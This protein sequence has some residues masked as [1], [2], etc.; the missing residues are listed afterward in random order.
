MYIPLG[1]KT[2]Y[3]LLQSLIKIKELIEFLSDNN[4]TSCGIIDNN[5]SYVMEFIN[6]CKKH[7]IKPNVGLSVKYYNKDIYLYAINYNGLQELFKINSIRQDREL[8]K[9]DVEK[10]NLIIVIP[11]KNRELIKD[12]NNFYISYE[13]ETEK[14]ESLLFTNNVVFINEVYSIYKNDLKYLDYLKSISTN[15]TIIDM[16]KNNYDNNYILDIN[17]KSTNKFSDRINIEIPLNNKYIPKYINNSYEYLVALSKK[18]LDK[19]LAGKNNNEYLSRLKYELDVINEMGFCDYFLIVYDYVK[20][21]KSNNILVGPGRGSAAGS[22]VSYTLGITEVDPIK[23]NLLFERFLNKDRITMPDIDID[24]EYTKRDQV[25]DYVKEKYGKDFVAPIMTYGTLGTKQVIRDVF[26]IFEIDEKTTSGVIAKINGNLNLK[27]NLKN[28]NIKKIILDIKEVKDAFNVALKLEGLKKYISIHAAGVIISSKD[29]DKVI[30]IVKQNNIILTGYT[31]EYLEELGLLKMDF[32]AL[33]NL[34]IISNILNMVNNKIKLNEIPLDDEKTY[35][36][37]SSGNTDGVFQFDTSGMKNFIVKLKPRTFSDLIAAVALFRPGPMN[38]IDSFI[39]RKNKEEKITYLDKSLEN[40][41]CDTYGI[42][43]YQ[44]QILEIL[45]SMGGYTY[46]QAD[47]VRRAM[48]KK[49]KEIMEKERQRF[50]E[51]AISLGYEKKISNNVYDLII[52]FAEYGFNKAH[53]V[54]YA[55]IGYYLA[56]LKANFNKEFII[57]LLNMSV[58]SEVKIKEYI[59]LAKKQDLKIIKPSINESDNEFIVNNQSVI[60]PFS[61]IK[62]IGRETSNTIIKEREKGLYKDF[63]DFVKRTYGRNVNKKTIELLIDSDAFKCFNYNH[64]TLYN[65]ID[66]AIN[67]AEISKDIDESLIM[68]PVISEYKEYDDNILI[69]KELDT[70]GFYIS[71]HPVTKYNSKTIKVEDIKKYYD[72][73]ISIYL[74][75]TN[76]QRIKTKNNDDMAFINGEDETGSVECVV[77]KDGYEQ[78]ENIKINTIILIN[79]VVSKRYDKYQIVIQMLSNV[80]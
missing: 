55:L 48:S 7:N 9:E 20:Y 2:D 17:E 23:Y 8:T 40:I 58:G 28:S 35:K 79:G 5:L 12:F 3:S 42:I 29:L 4:Y 78:I 45:K 41:L 76:I 38:N 51:G 77:F 32:L 59:D 27:D 54:S 68:K 53:S 72:K 31:M 57:C 49:N 64:N 63:L 47:I 13:T 60:L 11:F 36:L 65:N 24:F 14:T 67:Y 22:L 26:K 74:L 62:S 25:I 71:N 1:I 19:R 16:K 66:N 44:E 80:K 69:Q 18:G 70:F 43:V 30:P 75:I 50:V 61:S 56:Y 10:E 6:E 34:T 39:K 52:K 15:S 46:S 21:A 73:K 33:K 37:L